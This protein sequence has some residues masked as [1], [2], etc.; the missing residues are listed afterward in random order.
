MNKNKIKLYHYSNSN[1][2]IVKPCFFGKNN[3]TYNDVKTCKLARSFFY[4]SDTPLEYCFKNSKYLYVIEINKNNLYDLRTDKLN[5]KV[6]YNKDITG[7]L[8]Y[9]KDNYKGIIYNVGF[10]I[11]CLFYSV[12]VKPVI[13]G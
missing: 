8:N 13:K 2:D 4:L 1:F 6:K 7:L 9:C 5:L 10:D 11:V 3:F 12:R